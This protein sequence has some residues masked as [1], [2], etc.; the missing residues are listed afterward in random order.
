MV[1][2]FFDK[3][4]ASGAIT[5]S[6]AGMSVNEELHKPVIK[7]SKEEKYMRDLQT[8]FGNQI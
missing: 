1:Y 5:A 6:K 8:I 4:T 3:K 7:S 2:K